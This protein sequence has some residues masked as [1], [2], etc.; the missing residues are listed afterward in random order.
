[1]NPLGYLGPRYSS[2]LVKRA[3]RCKFRE[4]A[5]EFKERDMQTSCVYPRDKLLD[6]LKF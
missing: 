1:M 5:S 4:R 3:E 2:D 6:I